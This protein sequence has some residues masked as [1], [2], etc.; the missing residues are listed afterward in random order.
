MNPYHSPRDLRPLAKKGGDHDLFTFV[1]HPGAGG[2]AW[3]GVACET[4]KTWR[5]N[6]NKAY[7]PNQC[8]YYDPPQQ[9]DCTPTN[10][11]VLT[12]EVYIII[13]FAISL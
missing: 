2:V 12:A 1:T 4:T 8:N 11:I 6:F 9:I 10:R 5:I 13:H 3:G 7:G